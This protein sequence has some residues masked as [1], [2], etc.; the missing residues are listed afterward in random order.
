VTKEVV[1]LSGFADLDKALGELPRATAKSV[2]IRT[3][4]KAG[5][6]IAE[7]ARQL[8]PVDRG[9]LKESIIVSARLKNP[10]GKTEFAAAMKAGLGKAAAVGAL[11]DARRAAGG[12]SFAEMFVGAGALPHAHMI[13]FGTEKMAAQPFLRPAWDAERRGALDIIKKELGTEIIMAAKR[14]AKNK[15]KSADV[16]YRAS[17]AAMMAAEQGY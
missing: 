9:D 5:E 15:R 12:G 8:V 1:K 17:L 3:L 16:K 13:E 14:I 11:R 6:P 4:R 2:L 10:V 7:A